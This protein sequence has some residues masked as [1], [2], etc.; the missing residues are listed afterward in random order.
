MRCLR[1]ASL[2]VLL[3]GCGSSPPV[4]FFTLD[5]V[6]VTASAVHRI[7]APVQVGAV[8]IPRTL[9]RRGMVTQGRPDR[10]VISEQNRWGAPL[11]DLVTTVLTQDLVQRLS[12]DSVVLPEAAAPAGT[13]VIGLDILQFGPDAAGDVILDA[14][15]NLT[16]YGSDTPLFTRHVLLRAPAE[17]GSYAAQARG[18]S[19]LLG[20]LA[21]AMADA[22]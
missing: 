11:A 14:S 18:M 19:G 17:A 8:H 4:H 16:P 9:D 7:S 1:A 20:Q 12:P 15:W 3:S 6:S 13:R 2:L 21:D 5:P 22:L 10:L